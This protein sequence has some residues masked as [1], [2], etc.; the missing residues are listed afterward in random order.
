MRYELNGFPGGH[1]TEF[2]REV[3]ALPTT[4]SSEHSLSLEPCAIRREQLI[5]EIYGVINKTQLKKR[6]T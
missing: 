3:I 1:R 6:S 2:S 5:M 4:I